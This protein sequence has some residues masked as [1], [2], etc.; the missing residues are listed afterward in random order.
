MTINN[1][2]TMTLSSSQYHEFHQ[3]YI[4]RTMRQH[5]VRVQQAL[6]QIFIKQTAYFLWQ[7]STLSIAVVFFK[8]RQQ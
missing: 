1:D 3:W 5:Q 8:I 4:S 6:L 2:K 7:Q